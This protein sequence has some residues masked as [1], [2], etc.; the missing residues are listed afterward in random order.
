MADFGFETMVIEEGS[1][2][3]WT[4]PAND[5]KAPSSV[6]M[7]SATTPTPQRKTKD[8]LGGMGQ[9]AAIV[10]SLLQ[11]MDFNRLDLAGRMDDQRFNNEMARLC[12]ELKSVAQNELLR[13]RRENKD[14]KMTLS[15]ELSDLLWTNNSRIGGVAVTETYKSYE[16]FAKHE[17]SLD[18]MENVISA[19]DSLR[20]KHTNVSSE[21]MQQIQVAVGFVQIIQQIVSSFIDGQTKYKKGVA[22]TMS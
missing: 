12:D 7:A 9:D 19:V 11:Q 18:Q 14:A 1:G 21:F 2:M 4:P 8:Q 15:K 16:D 6:Q 20:T 5:A 10:L 3:P 13:L 22:Q 17:F